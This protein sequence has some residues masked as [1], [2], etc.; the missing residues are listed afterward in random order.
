MRT[1]DFRADER[2]STQETMIK[3]SKLFTLVAIILL[4]NE[5]LINPVIGSVNSGM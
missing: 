2:D 3:M 5:V 1:I 4:V